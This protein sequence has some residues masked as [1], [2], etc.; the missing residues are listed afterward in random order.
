MVKLDDILREELHKINKGIIKNRKSLRALLVENK[1]EN[2]EIDIS[3]LEY[4]KNNVSLPLDKIFLPINI[5]IIPGSSE[6]Y[7]MDENDARVIEELGIRIKKRENAYYISKSDAN[8]LVRRFPNC[9]QI[10]YTLHF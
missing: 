9:F 7:L 1:I 2:L 3:I 5:Y 8:K 4:I 10:L 6:G